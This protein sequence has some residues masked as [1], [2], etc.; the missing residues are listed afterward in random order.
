VGVSWLNVIV[1]IPG[2]ELCVTV[3]YVELCV[4]RDLDCVYQLVT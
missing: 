4:D 2:T 3:V 1:C